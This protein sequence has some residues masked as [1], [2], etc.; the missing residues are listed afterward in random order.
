MD[1]RN[2]DGEGIAK[3]VKWTCR[4]CGN[5]NKAG[6]KDCSRCGYEPTLGRRDIEAQRWAASHREED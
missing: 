2:W 4:M 1:G 3:A 5:E 6:N